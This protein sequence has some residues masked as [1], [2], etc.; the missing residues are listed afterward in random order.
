MSCSGPARSC[1]RA[2]GTWTGRFAVYHYGDLGIYHLL[3]PLA[4]GPRLANYVEAE[5]G[6]L[7][8]HDA[9]NRT[10][11]VATLRSFLDHGGHVSAAARDL[12]IERRTLYHCVGTITR[13]LGRDLANPDTRLRLSVALRALD[14]LQSHRAS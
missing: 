10:P 11:L 7:L 3:L 5:L 4:E 1:W 9:R 2:P 14:L 8:E 13:L 12:F 6:A